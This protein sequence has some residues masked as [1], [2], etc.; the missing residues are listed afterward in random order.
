MEPSENDYQKLVRDVQLL[1]QQLNEQQQLQQQ[2]EQ[3]LLQLREELL[4]QHGQGDQ[5]REERLPQEQ[6]KKAAEGA[7]RP[8]R[9]RG[10]AAGRSRR[11]RGYRGRTGSGGRGIGGRG[12]GGRDNIVQFSFY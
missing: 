5:P 1:L 11:L 8:L 3:Q 4:P 12:R 2:Q 9:K 10:V 6:E 7:A